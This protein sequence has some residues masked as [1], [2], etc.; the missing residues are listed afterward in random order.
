MGL[1]DMIMAFLMM[2]DGRDKQ[3]AERP[4]EPPHQGAAL[5]EP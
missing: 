3:L 2:K 4:K 1:P 5:M